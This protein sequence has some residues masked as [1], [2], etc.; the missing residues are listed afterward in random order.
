MP[1]NRSCQNFLKYEENLIF[2][3]YQGGI[4]GVHDDITIQIFMLIIKYLS[5]Y[6][7]IIFMK[8]IID[9]STAENVME[10]K[11]DI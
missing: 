7:N 9:M 6:D 5:K 1:C 2:F 11:D 8:Q 10:K 3:F 4:R